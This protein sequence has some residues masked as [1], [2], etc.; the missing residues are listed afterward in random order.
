MMD[1]EKNIFTGLAAHYVEAMEYFDY[2][3][4]V[5]IFL[6]GSQNYGLDYEHS[7]IDTKLIV[8]PTFKDIAFNRSPVSTTHVRANEEHIDFK[9]IR[10]Y[11]QTFRK[12]NLNFLEILFTDF[13]FLNEDYKT[14]WMRLVENREAIAHYNLFQAIKSMKGIA[15]EK[16]HAMEHAYPSKVDVLAKFG[17]DPKQVS[18]LVRVEEFIERYIAGE[19]YEDCLHP[20]AA[21][22]IMDIKLGKYNLEEARKIAKSSIG[23]IESIADEF[24]QKIENKGN[25]EV[26]ELLNDV[27]YNIMKIAIQTEFGQ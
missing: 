7:D 15:L 21:E 8:T 9:D 2:S 14:E 24:T 26:D 23:R 5:G 18:H 11:I 12:Q 19:P 10:L 22:F 4:I 25:P 16:Y 17:Y 27:Q 1:R 20:K 6:Q 13:R 3:R